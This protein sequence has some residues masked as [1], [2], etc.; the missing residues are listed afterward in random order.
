[1]KDVCRLCR[2]PP[3][4]QSLLD[5]ERKQDQNNKDQGKG[6]DCHVSLTLVPSWSTA[7]PLG[8]IYTI[9]AGICQIGLFELG[10]VI[11]SLCS[12][13]GDLM[14]QKLVNGCQL[15]TNCDQFHRILMS[16]AAGI[17]GALRMLRC[18]GF[19]P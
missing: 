9:P 19:L 5:Q 15:H 10:L 8:R 1:M 3:N 17:E 12:V 13:L 7:A 11:C 14:L 4:H 2:D 18:Q 16:A 6:F